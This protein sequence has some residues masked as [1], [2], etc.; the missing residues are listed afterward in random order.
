L[1]GVTGEAEFGLLGEEGMTAGCQFAKALG[2]T[3]AP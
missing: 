1:V 3:G 2:M